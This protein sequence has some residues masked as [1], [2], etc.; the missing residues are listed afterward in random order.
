MLTPQNSHEK[1]IPYAIRNLTIFI[2]GNTSKVKSPLQY[3]LYGNVNVK[4]RPNNQKCFC[5][6]RYCLC[7][8]L[9]PFLISPTS[10][11]FAIYVENALRAVVKTLASSALV[12]IHVYAHNQSSISDFITYSASI[13]SFPNMQT[14]NTITSTISSVSYRCPL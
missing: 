5:I 11:T 13:Q 12:N 6:I 8:Y 10:E 3:V 7:S 1:Y 2:D 9:F 14:C 4:A